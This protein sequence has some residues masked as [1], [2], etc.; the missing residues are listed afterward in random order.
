MKKQWLY[1]SAAVLASIIYLSLSFFA[2]QNPSAGRLGLNSVQ[3]I[4]LKFTIA[5]PYITTWFFAMYGLSRLEKYIRSTKNKKDGML[6]LLHSFWVGFLWVSGG[7]ILVALAGGLR[8]YFMLNMNIYPIITMI[9]NYLYVFP[10]LVGFFIMYRGVSKLRSSQELSV[11][12]YSGSFVNTLIVLIISAFYL[13]LIFT[14]PTRQFSS[15]PMIP[16]TYYLPDI[17][18]LV[19]IVAPIIVTWWLGFSIAFIMG[20]L[21]PYFTK[22]ELFK[23]TTRILYGIWAIIFT[24]I[25]IQSLLSLGTEKLYAI[26]L[27]LL[28][29]LI[30]I[31]VILQGIGY[32]FLAFGA[33]TLFNSTNKK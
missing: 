5:I 21:I 8:S 25:L 15:D 23:G 20:D 12:K 24:S 11:Y 17:L 3:L 31:F 7:T 10:P 13:F 27:G 30:Y 16:A 22:A 9:M 14:N 4:F 1:Y 19:T 18:I 29:L 6:A 26:G 32:F 2:P 28:L 33:N